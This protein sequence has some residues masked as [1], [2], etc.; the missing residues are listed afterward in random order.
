MII[1][2]K[3]SPNNQ[4][5]YVAALPANVV[6]ERVEY[7]QSIIYYILAASVL[8]GLIMVLWLSYKNSKPIQDVMRT[9]TEKVGVGQP[10][11]VNEYEFIKRSVWKLIESNDTLRE[12]IKKQEPLLKMS[13]I[14]GCKR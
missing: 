13:F 3:V 5:T 2:Y 7:I 14:E 11:G 9:I 8:L 12:G 6:M 1:S 10:K 4:W